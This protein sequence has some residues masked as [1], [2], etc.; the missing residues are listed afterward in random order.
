MCHVVMALVF[1]YFFDPGSGVCLWAA[2]D[3]AWRQFGYP[4]EL[5]ALPLSVNTRLAAEELIGRFDSGIDW[6]DPA[7]PSPWTEDDE[8]SFLIAARQVLQHIREE[9][10]DE[11]EVRDELQCS[12]SADDTVKLTFTLLQG[13]EQPPQGV[14]AGD[15][16][17]FALKLLD[18]MIIGRAPGVDFRV[19]APSV[20]MRVVRLTVQKEGIWVEDLGSGGGSAVVIHGVTITRPACYLTD[21]AI[22]RIGTLSFRIG[23]THNFRR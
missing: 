16:F 19:V 17:Q 2:N 22:L 15:S 14:S 5:E 20:G 8:L 21:G 13:G 6:N 9:L 11:F 3:E 10:G 7:G 1:R 4:V 18:S 12:P 23:I